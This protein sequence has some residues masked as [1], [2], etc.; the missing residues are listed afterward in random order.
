MTSPTYTSA[1]SAKVSALSLAILLMQ[2][3]TVLAAD[4]PTLQLIDNIA[5]A[6]YK[7]G[8]L[9]AAP[10]TIDSNKVRVKS[11]AL[12]E[13]GI[14]L[15]EP[16]ILTVEPGANISWLNVLKN[17]SYSD[18]TVELTWSLPSTLSNLQVYQDINKNGLVDAGDVL[19]SHLKPIKISQGE[20]I[21]LITQAMT[22]SNMSN[23]YISDIKISATVLEDKSITAAA[24]DRLI[25]IK[26]NLN[27]M[28]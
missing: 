4:E 28:L 8:N 12:P 5:H 23:G 7:V 22:D 20:S 15:T 21:Q 18:Q 2:S 17:T 10:L 14:Q 26:P 24:T 16:S 1:R 25:V 9:S 3:N 11:S 19:L 6:S 13:Y 27:F